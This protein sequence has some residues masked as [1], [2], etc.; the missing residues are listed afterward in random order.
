[1]KRL[2]SFIYGVPLA[3]IIAGCPAGLSNPEDF[4]DGGAVGKDAE[5]ILAES[6]GTSGCHDATPSAVAGLDLVS[7]GVEARVV[8]VNS[9]CEARILV[10]AGD[11]DGSY[12]LD[13]VV[14]APMICG[15]PMPIVGTLTPDEVEV[16]RQWIIDLG[17][18]GSGAPDGG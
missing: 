14:N 13:K 5:T 1:M 11:P 18:P 16:L 12:L 15:L 8:E 4:T 17:E 9:T 6:C 10:V 7:P 3:A 2:A